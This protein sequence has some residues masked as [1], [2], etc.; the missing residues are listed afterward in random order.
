MKRIALAA[1]LAAYVAAPAPAQKKPPSGTSN[2]ELAYLRA[3]GSGADL[4]IANE[5][6]T[7]ALLIHRGV[8]G[9]LF[10][11]SA[12]DKRQA[13]V[14]ENGLKLISW[15][16]G[17][18]G[19]VSVTRFTI[20]TG[21]NRGE[22]PQF[23]RDGTRLAY[24]DPSDDR[25]HI[26]DPVNKAEITSWPS[27]FA[28]SITWYADGSGLVVESFEPGVGMGLWEYD[29]NG[30]ETPGPF[31]VEGRFAGIEAS[32]TPGSKE[33]LVAHEPVGGGPIRIRRFDNGAYVGGPLVT[34]AGAQSYKCDNSRFV[35]KAFG[36]NPESSIFYN[37]NGSTNLFSKESRVRRVRYVKTC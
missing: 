11:V 25:I 16:Y 13:V 20:P 22:A 7:G 1:L 27:R 21:D 23:S 18:S 4:Y 26:Y 28:F 12:R 19:T 31:L 29:L 6:G 33:L 17:G 24:Y 10:D 37:A 36:A 2:A 8:I 15:T 14:N 9:L 5:D 35:Y 34:F 32:R 30:V 3:G